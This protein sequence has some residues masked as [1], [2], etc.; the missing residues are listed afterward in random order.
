MSDYV[1]VTLSKHDDLLEGFLKSVRAAGETCVVAVADDGLA[2][3]DWGAY[4]PVELVDGPRWE[5]QGRHAF[6]FWRSCNLMFQQFP[7]RDIFLVN[8]DVELRGTGAPIHFL[9]ETAAK[10]SVGLVSPA[11]DGSGCNEVQITNAERA[12]MGRPPRE[13]VRD[14]GE[15]HLVFCGVFISAR[16]RQIAGIFPHGPCSEDV[17][18]SHHVRGFGM[19]NMVDGRCEIWHASGASRLRAGK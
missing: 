9:A 3:K 4:G 16:V 19:R 17:W 2:R 15:E 11:V 10:E 18:Y 7:T 12:R 1:V 14:A 8:D 6:M 13:L 5:H